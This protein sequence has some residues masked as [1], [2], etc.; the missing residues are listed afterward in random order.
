LFERS[1]DNIKSVSDIP[2]Q[3]RRT[4]R[5]E[6]TEPSQYVATLIKPSKEFHQN[7]GDPSGWI[8]IIFGSITKEYARIISEVLEGRLD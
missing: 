4:N 5:P 8:E 3:Y 7:T 2:R 6:P 1:I